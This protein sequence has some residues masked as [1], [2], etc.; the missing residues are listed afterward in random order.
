MTNRI[1]VPDSHSGLLTA[2]LTAVLTTI[3]PN[4]QPQSTAV[5]YLVDT[6]AC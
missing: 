4:G 5:W 1:T 6:T 2:P 3:N